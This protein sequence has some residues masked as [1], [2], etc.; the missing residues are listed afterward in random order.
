MIVFDSKTGNV[1]RFIKKLGMPAVQITPDL[2]MEQPFI[3]ITYTSGFGQV[4]KLH[5]HFYKPII[6]SYKELLVVVTA[7]GVNT[8][9]LQEEL[10]QSNITYR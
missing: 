3:L 7:T 2:V 5:S 9:Q 4:Q 6:H 10:F 8:S 1:K